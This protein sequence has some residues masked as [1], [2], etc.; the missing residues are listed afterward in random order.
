MY[1]DEQRDPCEVWR[2]LNKDLFKEEGLRQYE[3]ADKV[4]ANWRTTLSTM[5][6]GRDRLGFDNV[7]ELLRYHI[8]L[9]GLKLPDRFQIWLVRLRRCPGYKLNDQEAEELRKVANEEFKRM[10]IPTS[11]FLSATLDSLCR[12]IKAA[13]ELT[14]LQWQNQ[15]DHKYRP[16]TSYF[17]SWRK[18]KVEEKEEHGSLDGE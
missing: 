14:Y 4:R 9:R 11:D 3:F 1:R 15:L 5:L 12:G 17:R 16:L 13:D 10:G 8:Q 6:G 2:K 18:K 7:V